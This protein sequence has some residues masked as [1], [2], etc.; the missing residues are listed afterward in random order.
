MKTGRNALTPETAS[1]QGLRLFA[2]VTAR[3]GERTHNPQ[4]AGSNP[5]PATVIAG[6]APFFMLGSMAPIEP[7]HVLDTRAR[8][9]APDYLGGVFLYL[10]RPRIQIPP[11]PKQ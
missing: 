4:V 10:R 5:A 11:L 3:V 9:E 2:Q 6:Q 7:G 1:D 8:H